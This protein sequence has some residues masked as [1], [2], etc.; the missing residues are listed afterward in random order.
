MSKIVK[1][2]EYEIMF[3]AECNQTRINTPSESEA[4][5]GRTFFQLIRIFFLF[6]LEDLYSAYTKITLYNTNDQWL[7]I[8][9]TILP[10]SSQYDVIFYRH[11]QKLSLDWQ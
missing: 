4:W 10:I 3:S 5:I 8:T 7:A 11:Y 6:R 9:Q 2:F 1:Y